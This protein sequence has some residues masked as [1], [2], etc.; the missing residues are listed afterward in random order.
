MIFQFKVGQA[1]AKRATEKKKGC[2]LGLELRPGREGGI[3]RGGIKQKDRHLSILIVFF[4]D[5]GGSGCSAGCPRL[6]AALPLSPGAVGQDEG[7]RQAGGSR[8]CGWRF[9]RGKAAAIFSYQ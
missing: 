1:S 9:L 5:D 6:R 3:V 4:L 7:E 2:G 8:G